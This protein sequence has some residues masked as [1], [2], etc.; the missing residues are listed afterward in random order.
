MTCWDYG[1]A[2][3]AA[4]TAGGAAVFSGRDALADDALAQAL[5]YLNCA[6]LLVTSDTNLIARC[7]ARRDVATLRSQD[8]GW[9][10]PLLS[11]IHI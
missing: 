11:L 2:F 6:C 1:D 5:A 9:A 3:A 4:A 10:L 7:R 8:F